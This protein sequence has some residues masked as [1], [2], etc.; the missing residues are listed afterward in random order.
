MDYEQQEAIDF[1]QALL[2]EY[3]DCMEQRDFSSVIRL[4]NMIRTHLD[5]SE[6]NGIHLR[7]KVKWLPKKS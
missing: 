2:V 5:V 7:D 4:A 1:L 6:R 3:E